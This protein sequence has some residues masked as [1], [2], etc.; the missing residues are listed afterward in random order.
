MYEPPI[1]LILGDMRTKVDNHVFEVVQNV[2]VTVDRNELIKALQ[3][4]RQQYKKGF[5]DGFRC[6]NDKIIRCKE[7]QFYGVDRNKGGFCMRPWSPSMWRDET[8]YLKPDDFCSY[9]VRKEQT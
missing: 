8:G 7:C 2:G 6:A 1:E 9:A 4:D 3:Y 5:E